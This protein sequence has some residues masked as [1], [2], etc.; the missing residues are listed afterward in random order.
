MVNHRRP[1][2]V[3]AI[4]I[5]IFCCRSP[6]G[7]ESEQEKVEAAK[8]EGAVYWYG[9]MNVDDASAL[10]AGLNKKYPFMEIKR[11]R[12]ANAPILSKLDVE[13]RARGLN[14]DVIDLDGFYVAQALKRNYWVRYVS[15]ELAAY[16]K[17]LSDPAGRWSG[18]FLLPQVVIYNTNLVSSASAPKSYNDLLDPRWKNLIAIPDSGVTWYHGMLQYMG[19]EKGRSFM[20]RLAAQNVHVQ[21][22][23]RMMVEL[24]MAGEHAIG[25]AAYAHRIGQFQKRGA[26]M[27][28]IKDDVL[29]TTP[30]AIGVSGYGKSPNAAKLILDFTLSQEG[31]TILRRS[32]RIPANPK[33]DP[34]PP[35]LLRGRKLFY[36]DIIDG[37]T[38]YNEINDE[39]LKVFA[40]R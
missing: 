31:Q 28:W 25:M 36:S 39:F 26:P 37:G 24:T 8:K 33:V 21:A 2:G 9:S 15:P 18:F 30:Q 10:I 5:A 11:T 19:A 13:A 22:G 17:E 7:A 29:V 34:D 14:V 6:A 23:N 35:E 40:G 12:A 16:P 32:G 1:A 3:I 20:K 27:G 4:V 38:R